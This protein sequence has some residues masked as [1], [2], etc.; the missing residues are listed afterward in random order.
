MNKKIDILSPLAVYADI[1]EYV[2][3]KSRERLVR[4]SVAHGGEFEAMRLG[5]FLH[6]LNGDYSCIGLGGAEEWGRMMVWQYFW[7]IGFKE[8]VE[9]FTQALKQTTI[10]ETANETKAAAGLLPMS[11]EESVLTFCRDYFNLPNFDIDGLHVWEFMLAKKAAYNKVL[12][13]R[14]YDKIMSQ[15]MKSK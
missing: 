4:E 6:A 9:T 13:Q 5:D 8:Y 15:K 2:S 12:F 3:G 1:L 11:L 7:L 14:N 10:K